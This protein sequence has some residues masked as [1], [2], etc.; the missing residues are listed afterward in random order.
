[1]LLLLL[2]LLAACGTTTASTNQS[3]PSSATNRQQGTKLQPYPAHST[4]TPRSGNASKN[5]TGTTSGSNNNQ[6]GSKNTSPPQTT[7]PAGSTPQASNPTPTGSSGIS[8][9]GTAAESQVTQQLFALINSDRAAQRLPAYSW[10]T[11]L[12]NGARQHSIKMT[13]CGLSHACSGEPNPC[14]RVLNEG[15]NYMACGENVGYSSPNPDAFGGARVIEQSM[16]AEQPPNDGHRKNLLS[17]TFHQ[18]GVG[19]VIDAQGL[20]WITEDFTN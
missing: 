17:S 8:T 9:G 18:A 11:T 6:S 16:L 20:V 13:Q 12:A 3:T 2:L 19:I 15:I 7:P 4:P 5:K 10:N 1:M 14:Q